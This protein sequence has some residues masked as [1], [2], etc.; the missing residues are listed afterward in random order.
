MPIE[1]TNFEALTYTGG[2]AG[3]LWL[4]RIIYKLVRKDIQEVQD[5]KQGDAILAQYKD[6]AQRYKLEADEQ[7]KKADTY[8]EERNRAIEELGKLR[9]EVI[10]LT[11]L[12]EAMDAKIK[13]LTQTIELMN[14]IRTNPSSEDPGLVQPAKED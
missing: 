5:S 12:V 3:V 10:R 14:K 7:A 13:H 9:G 1:V 11:G 8:A 4:L 6:L 2:G